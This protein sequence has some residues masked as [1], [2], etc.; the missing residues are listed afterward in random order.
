MKTSIADEERNLH[1]V[2]FNKKH[3]ADIEALMAESP[4]AARI[5]MF[6]VEKM[7]KRNACIMSSTVL[8]ERFDKSRQ[9]IYLAV[10]VLVDG[11]FMKT[12]R[13]SGATVYTLNADVVWQDHGNK[14]QFAEFTGSIVIARSEQ[15]RIDEEGFMRTIKTSPTRLVTVEQ[16]APSSRRGRQVRAQI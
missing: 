15:K 3:L 11:G 6:I 7:D 13:S 2:Q 5:F 16:T 14:K 8:Q 12:Y 9:S 4:L 1:F 10:R